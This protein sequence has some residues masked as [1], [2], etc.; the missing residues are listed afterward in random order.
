MVSNSLQISIQ[1]LHQELN[2]VR[3]KMKVTLYFFSPEPQVGFYPFFFLL[4][5]YDD[6]DLGV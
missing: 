2:D 1:I 3:E 5:P 6:L 4:S